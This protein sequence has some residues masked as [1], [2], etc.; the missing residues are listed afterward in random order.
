MGKLPWMKFCPADWLSDPLLR[1]VGPLIKGVW[2]DVLCLM[3]E[4]EQRGVL[5]GSDEGLRRSLALEPADWQAFKSAAQ[6][7][8]FC[9]FVCEPNGNLTLKNRRMTRDEKA[10]ENNA[11][12]QRKHYYNTR[13]LTPESVSPNR[14]KSEV[15]S[16]KSE[17]RI[18]NE[19]LSAPSEP[20]SLEPEIV[21]PERSDAC[22]YEAIRAAYNTQ[23]NLS[24]QNG[25]PGLIGCRKLEPSEPLGRAVRLAW[26]ANGDVELGKLFTAAA[27][28]PFCCGK[29]DRTWR[30]DLKFV[31]KNQDRIIGGFYGAQSTAQSQ[32]DKRKAESIAFIQAH[33][34]GGANVR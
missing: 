25:L 20:H 33:S 3:W 17:V 23:A 21:K 2:I 26:K 28:S 10:R 13:D 14:E 32:A 16:Q 34:I 18:K 12:R 29:N 24:A 11:M 15:R 30:A 8:R 5:T 19:E 6:S 9:E 7:V 1:Q 31:L 27:Q 4:S 22:P